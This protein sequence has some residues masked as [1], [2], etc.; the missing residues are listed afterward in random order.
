MSSHTG[1]GFSEL[2]YGK[3]KK[4]V[5]DV[6]LVDVEDRLELLRCGLVVVEELLDLLRC[7]SQ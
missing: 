3:K 6:G 4:D 7:V 5:P 2:L 1:G